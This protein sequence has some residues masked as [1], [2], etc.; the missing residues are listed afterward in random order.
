MID[1]QNLLLSC[2]NLEIG[3]HQ[4]LSQQISFELNKGDIL[5]VKGRNGSGKT[6]FLKTILA[7]ISPKGGHFKWYTNQESI[8]YLPQITNSFSHFS[9]NVEEILNIYEVPRQIKN[10]FSEKLLLKK[11]INLSGGE[12]QKVLLLTRLNEK[13]KVLILDEPFNHLDKESIS[14]VISLLIR[15]I[16]N[17]LAIIL[18]SHVDVELTCKKVCLS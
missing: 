2:F 16:E 10:Y 17:D 14:S 9:F 18:V 13:S 15:L 3:Y 12:K 6:T 4:T 7:Q 5:Y 8:S 11:W 1:N